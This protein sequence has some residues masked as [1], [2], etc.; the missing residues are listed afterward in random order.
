MQ[1][2]INQCIIAFSLLF[3]SSCYKFS[4]PII[5]P[6]GSSQSTQTNYSLSWQ[7]I[8]PGTTGGNQILSII[9]LS[10]GGYVWTGMNNLQDGQAWVIR[11]DA[12]KNIIWEKS[13]GGTWMDAGWSIAKTPDGGFVVAGYASSSNGDVTDNHGPD[14]YMDGWVFKLDAN[15]NVVWKH[16][17]GGTA[18]DQ[19]FNVIVN[20]DGTIMVAGQSDS[21]DGDVT[22][23]HGGSDLWLVKLDANGNKLWAKTYGGSGNDYEGLIQATSDGGY[24][25]VGSSGSSDGDIPANK[26]GLDI[27]V[28]KLDAN[29]NKQWVHNYGGSQDE[30]ANALLVASDGG[31]VIAGTT[32]SSDGDVTGQHGGGA[33]DYWVLRLS[34]T[35]TKVWATA[36]GG[37]DEDQAM[38]ITATSAGGYMITGSSYST[39]GDVTAGPGNGD[40]WTV[41]INSGGSKLWEKS[42]G[43]TQYD[44]GACVI[45]A[46]DGGI[47]IGGYAN[48]N[49]GD[50]TGGPAGG[51]AWLLEIK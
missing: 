19:F 12:A 1:N 34:S 33:D 3:F 5:P 6:P 29:G 48:G 17:M 28:L 16:A 27:V 38:A 30:T 18:F 23:Q 7:K 25:L 26:G 20:T 40:M 32:S 47:V 8:I 14:G 49:D 51:G 37:T 11:T 43:S 21:W 22:G 46:A 44:G 39:D 42:Y 15:G 41:N 4:I 36:L 35:G 31:F 2:R 9:Q 45:R 13:L 50:A 10:D 24:V